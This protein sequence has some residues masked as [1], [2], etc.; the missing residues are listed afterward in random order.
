MKEPQQHSFRTLPTSSLSFEALNTYR[1][2]E[3]RKNYQTWLG[4][5]I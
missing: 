5:A 3:Q 4:V 1:L 2:S